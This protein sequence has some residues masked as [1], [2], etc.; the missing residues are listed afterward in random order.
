M[1]THQ[2][3]FLLARTAPPI[4]SLLGALILTALALAAPAAPRDGAAA[5]LGSVN[6]APSPERPV[7]WRDAADRLEPHDQWQRIRDHRHRVDDAPA[8]LER[9]H[10]EHCW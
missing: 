4:R 2:N 1:S 3:Q 5:L 6:F 10:A 7:G 8:E 9:R